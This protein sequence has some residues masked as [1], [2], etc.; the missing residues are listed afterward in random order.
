MGRGRLPRRQGSLSR[1][2]LIYGFVLAVVLPPLLAVL[3]DLGGDTLNLTS[4]VLAFLFAVVVVAL[5]GGLWPALLTAV[6]RHRWC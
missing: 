5:V 4:D 1:R 3:L 2:R 6:G